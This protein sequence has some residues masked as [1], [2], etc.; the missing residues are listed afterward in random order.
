MPYTTHCTCTEA[1]LTHVGCDCDRT[2]PEKIVLT[3]DD[4]IAAADAAADAALDALDALELA[5]RV[6]EAAYWDGVHA[7]YQNDV[8]VDAREDFY[9]WT[10]EA[11]KHQ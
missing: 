11:A 10:L 5:D 7:A 1:Q 3:L 8:I 9:E 6:S 2:G 4:Q